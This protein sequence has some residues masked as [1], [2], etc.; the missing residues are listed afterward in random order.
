MGDPT[1]IDRRLHPEIRSLVQLDSD[2]RKK[3]YFSGPLKRHVARKPDGSPSENKE[4]TDM[5]GQLGGVVLSLWDSKEIEAAS[6]RGEEVPP[7]YINVTDA[8][9]HVLGS[10]TVP[11]TATTPAKKFAQVIT[12]NTAGSNLLL[13]SC[14]SPAEVVSWAAAIRMAAWEKSRL[15]EIYTGHILRLASFASHSTWMNPPSPLQ[16][17]RMEGWVRIRLACHV[18]WKR[19]WLV[20]QSNIVSASKDSSAA[21]QRKNPM[22]ILFPRTRTAPPLP[23][24]SQLTFYSTSKPKDTKKAI[25]TFTDLTQAFAVYPEK[26]ELITRSSLIKLEGTIGEEDFAGEMKGREGWVLVMVGLGSNPEEQ[27]TGHTLKW[28]TGIHDAFGMYGRPSRYEWDPRNEE[29]VFFVYPFGPHRD[30]SGSIG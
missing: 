1:A 6:G 8:F 24:K 26:P 20:V 4:W 30:V 7:T 3:I 18:E 5:W 9:V 15:E 10:V 14:P 21:G 12:L 2:L 29:S 25:L 11:A 16:R 19:V 13:F 27:K 22:S 23:T 17:G 28:L